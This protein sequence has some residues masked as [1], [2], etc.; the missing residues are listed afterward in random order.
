MGEKESILIVDDD[1]GT[2]KTLKLIF[3]R[4]GFE[5]ETVNTRKEALE[6]LQ[7]RYFNLIILDI[8]LPDFDG[9]ELLIHLKKL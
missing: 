7:K 3:N 5:T 6:T 2:C 8:I 1:E 9:I 4:K